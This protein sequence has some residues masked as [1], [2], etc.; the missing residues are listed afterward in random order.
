MKQIAAALSVGFAAW[1][2]SYAQAKIGSAGAGVIAEKPEL[3]G[4]VLVFMAL[5]ELMVLFGFVVSAM[6]LLF[7]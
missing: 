4:N 3:F 7:K 6:I 5:P 1:A 2:T